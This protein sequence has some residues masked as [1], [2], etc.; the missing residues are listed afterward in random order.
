MLRIW[1][2]A[3]MVQLMVSA[4]V[5]AAPNVIVV[6]TDDQGYGDLSCHG[7]PHLE[8][9]HLDGLREESTS[10]DR[11]FVSP[12]GAPTRAALMTGRHEFAV[13]VSHSILGRSLLRPG[14]QTLP[15]LMGKAGYA[16]G[17][18][19]KWHL[20]DAYPCRP[21]DRG[22]DEVFVHGAGG[23]AEMGDAWGNGYLNP[24]IRKKSGW[25]ETEGDCTD[26][27]FGEAS[28]W[29]EKQAEAEKPFFL[30][31]ATNTPHGPH[32]APEGTADKFEE[33]GLAQPVAAFYAMIEN[34]DENM[35]RF[36]DKVKSL[37]I[38]EDTIVI[39]VTDNGSAM[40]VF[41]AGMKGGKATPY[42]GGVRVPCFIRWPG[43]IEAGKVVA[44]PAAHVDLLPTLA[45]LCGADLPEEWT[46]DGVD[47]SEALRG[48]GEF[49]SGRSFFTHVGRW[50]G[51]DRPERYRTQRFSVRNDR[52]RLVGLALYDMENDE[53]Q[54][55]D[56]F[57]EHQEVAATML[58]DYGRWWDSVLPSLREPVRYVIGD[59]AHPRIDLYAHDWWPSLE[60]SPGG[61]VLMWNQLA[62]RKYLENAMLAKTRNALPELSG[63]WK[64]K[65]VRPGNYMVRM[66]LVP[67]DASEEERRTLGKLRPGVAHVRVGKQEVQLQVME[68][69]SSVAVGVDLDEGPADLEAWFSGQLPDKRKLGA[70]FVSIER[71]GEK[72]VEL[73]EVQVVPE[74]ELE[75]MKKEGE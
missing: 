69:A 28:K 51:D 37:G 38:E 47:L 46:G 2:K 35:G 70:M 27:V 39:F 13:G 30:W 57:S 73:P 12:S 45:G 18:F 40:P 49:P 1:W 20:G 74:E 60:G 71:K 65:A 6:I 3:A 36:L 33:A 61:Q 63:H 72:S 25:V 11:F 24:K 4:S 15:E 23:I 17:I 8:T 7:N 44:S 52:W 48:E 62:A 26:V 16:T 66:S 21:E 75:K 50:D 19:G 9:P 32:E 22:F 31:L 42:E 29:M 34:I 14:I 43:E 10:L 59:E 53:G 67:L 58:E 56:V 68:G 54:T 5:M 64:L 55:T 41:T